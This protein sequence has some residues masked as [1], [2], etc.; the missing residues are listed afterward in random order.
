MSGICKGIKSDIE[1]LS[2]EALETAIDLNKEVLANA[3]TK[4]DK[5]AMAAMQ[6]LCACPIAGPH[7]QAAN[8]SKE[9]VRQAD[10]LLAELEKDVEK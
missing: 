7:N 4:R 10:A 5:F 9:A 8:L 6:G 2:S 1:S 3:L